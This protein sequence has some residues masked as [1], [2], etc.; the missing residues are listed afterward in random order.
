MLIG[1]QARATAGEAS[2]RVESDGTVRRVPD[3]SQQVI[4]RGPLSTTDT[5]TDRAVTHAG[6]TPAHVTTTQA[7]L[8]GRMSI[9][10]PVSRAASR[11]FCPSRPI[12]RESW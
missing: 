7:S 10:Q 9:R 5:G 8:S 1:V 11:A 4:A 6:T 2:G 3:H 12:A